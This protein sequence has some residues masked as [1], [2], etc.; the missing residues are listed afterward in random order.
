MLCETF[1]I[2]DRCNFCRS[3]IG[4]SYR[5]QTSN[6]FIHSHRVSVISKLS[7]LH[8]S[9]MQPVSFRATPKKVGDKRPAKFLVFET[10]KRLKRSR[11][12]LRP[13]PMGRTNV[14]KTLETFC[15][16]CLDVSTLHRLRATFANLQENPITNQEMKRSAE[17]TPGTPGSSIPRSEIDVTIH[18]EDANPNVWQLNILTD[19]F[20][21][22]VMKRTMGEDPDSNLHIK[23]GQLRTDSVP[24]VK[25]SCI[26]GP[27]C[28]HPVITIPGNVRDTMLTTTTM[29]MRSTIHEVIRYLNDAHVVYMARECIDGDE[30]GVAYTHGGIGR[31][32]ENGH[33]ITNS[34]L[35]DYDNRIATCSSFKLTGACDMVDEN[36]FHQLGLG[37]IVSNHMPAH[38]ACTSKKDAL[39]E[40]HPILKLTVVGHT[41]QPTGLPIIC[42]EYTVSEKNKKCFLCTGTQFKHLEENTSATLVFKDGSF[43]GKGEWLGNFNYE[44]K[45][46][47]TLI[48]TRLSIPD[49][50][51]SKSTTPYFRV[52][53]RVTS[54]P[55][56]DELKGLYICVNLPE[57][58][59]GAAAAGKGAYHEDTYTGTP[60]IAFVEELEHSMSSFMR[61]LEYKLHNVQS[62][63]IISMINNVMM[64]VILPASDSD[65]DYKVNQVCDHSYWELSDSMAYGYD[66]AMKQKGNEKDI[67]NED[68]EST[69]LHQPYTNL[70]SIVGGDME[71][72]IDFLHGFLEHAC[73]LLGITRGGEDVKKANEIAPINV[74]K[75]EPFRDSGFD[76]NALTAK[77]RMVFHLSSRILDLR[78]STGY[79][80][81]SLACIGNCIGTPTHCSNSQCMLDNFLCILWANW[82][83]TIR[84]VGNRELSKLRLLSEIPNALKPETRWGIIELNHTALNPSLA[85]ERER[86][87]KAIL[88]SLCYPVV[89]KD[90]NWISKHRGLATSPEVHP[91]DEQTSPWPGR[92]LCPV[93][94][95]NV[96]KE[97]EQTKKLYEFFAKLSKKAKTKDREEDQEEG[98]EEGQEEDT[99]PTPTPFQLPPAELA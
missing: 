64:E 57:A 17:E 40:M 62:E 13:D 83:C 42:K 29:Y 3:M 73:D 93:W 23:D 41:P 14:S 47:D 36:T 68:T 67:D 18:G 99:S 6:R 34:I 88:A 44:F 52:I 12:S 50:D 43:I 76:H 66:L 59:V 22:S 46:Y 72:S 8:V 24:D 61:I 85:E 5:I 79:Y 21:K 92:T 96:D 45:S 27:F 55:G 75:Y 95:P 53:G 37:G 48:G 28:D 98:Q 15:N 87:D 86:K 33:M 49:R 35:P 10:V 91:L 90:G 56:Q 11:P 89:Q 19:N 58:G 20:L 84:I 74:N 81:F 63:E 94:K 4:R 97:E 80:D 39:D 60:K 70:H 51:I 65:E 77:Q 7:I 71:G 82:Y 2:S 30:V 69:L 16:P 38:K 26:V 32:D 54:S 25:I 1:Q 9:T 78:N 31:M